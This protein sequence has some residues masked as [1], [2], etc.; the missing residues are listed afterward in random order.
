MY[1]RNVLVP[2]VATGLPHEAVRSAAVIAQVANRGVNYILNKGEIFRTKSRQVHCSRMCAG[3]AVVQESVEF[4]LF[5]PMLSNGSARS[6]GHISSISHR[7]IKKSYYP[8]PSAANT[9]KG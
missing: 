5:L 2:A 9:R 4:N 3:T 7:V 6:K 8:T 1:A